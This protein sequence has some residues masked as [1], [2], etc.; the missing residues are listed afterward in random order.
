MPMMSTVTNGYA[1]SSLYFS[2]SNIILTAVGS[3]GQNVFFLVHQ[4]ILSKNSPVFVHM[5]SSPSEGNEIY[6]GVPLVQLSDSRED[7]ES[8]MG[9]LN[10]D[11]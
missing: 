10:H 2:D 9:V 1:H 11:M 4:S 5:L 7:W 3:N 8:L 6:D